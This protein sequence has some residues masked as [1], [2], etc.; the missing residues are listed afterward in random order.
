MEK[1]VKI[2]R[3]LHDP[4]VLDHAQYDGDKPGGLYESFYQRANHPTKPLAFWIRYTV[5]VPKGRPEAAIGELW[6]VFFDGETGE[7]TVMKEEFP[8]AECS[9]ST[10]S[11]DVR[12]GEAVLTPGRLVGGGEAAGGRSTWDLSYKSAHPPVLLQPRLAYSLEFPKAKSLVAH[13]LA[14][15]D[16]VLT[17]DGR[18]IPIRDWVG[19]QNHNWGSAHTDKYAFAQVAGFNEDPEGFLEIATAQVRLAGPVH[20][21]WV[22]MLVLRSHGREYDMSSLL[23]AFRHRAKYS[24]FEWTFT[25]ENDRARISGRISA[26]REAFVGLVYYNPSGGIKHCLNTK[27]GRCELQV[28]DKTDGRE[29]T[30]TTAHRALFEILTDDRRHGITIRA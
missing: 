6:F 25:A 3:S 15:F 22:T 28:A 17:V 19:S 7:H 8:I 9:F 1:V 12:I 5:F 2:A 14:V 18:E 11:F 27:I 20:T 29:F 4:D 16:G 21:P 30:L 24:Y 26:P 10:N 13:P 23:R